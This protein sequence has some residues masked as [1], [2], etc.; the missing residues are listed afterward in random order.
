MNPLIK[1]LPGA[2]LIEQGLKDLLTSKL[3]IPAL[4]ICIAKTRLEHAGLVIPHLDQ[5]PRD[6]E[7]TL[8]AQI[9]QGQE[10]DPYSYYNSLIR[11]LIAFEK[12]L[13]Q[14]QFQKSG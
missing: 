14:R 5:M 12:G 2:E 10:L 13:E 8:Y 1:D 6:L 7:L 4:L 11:L 9:Q 3:T